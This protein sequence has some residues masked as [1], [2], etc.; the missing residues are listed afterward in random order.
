LQTNK[1]LTKQS[2]GVMRRIENMNKMA[3]VPLVILLLTSCSIIKD[4][5]VRTTDYIEED[6][7]QKIYV[8]EFDDSGNPHI[9]KQ[10]DSLI[11][12]L[13][14][15]NTE[16]N[17][18]F[19]VHG[20]HHN[21]SIDDSNY[22]GFKEFLN[23]LNK[24]DEKY[25]GVYIGWRGDQNDP[26]WIDGTI[27]AIDFLTL[28]ER[29]EVSV[30]IGEKGVGNLLTKIDET[31]NDAYIKNVVVIGHSLGGSAVFHAS[32]ERLIRDDNF[33]YLL[34]NPALTDKE[35]KPIYLQQSKESKSPK[36]VTL[37]SKNDFAVNFIFDL[38]NV[39]EDSAGNS[40]AISHDLDS[41]PYGDKTCV[42]SS[43]VSDCKIVVNKNTWKV[44]ARKD[45][46]RLRETCAETNMLNNWL[47]AVDSYAIDNHN[48]ILEFNQAEAL[49]E[50]LI[51]KNTSKIQGEIITSQSTGTK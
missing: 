47:I 17:I 11:N 39:G 6:N 43:S 31:I 51:K 13:A 28:R 14:K 1:L 46:G 26:L 40:W 29:K 10:I 38:L 36:M 41:C 49:V 25:T 22:V 2:S 18:V 37:Q 42:I 3:I 20:W 21:A 12:D 7:G 33:F 23:H 19:F 45:N 16:Q 30:V 8:I 4:E 35:Y 27:E 5:P 15:N 9:E 34:L 50:F 48:G 24:S 32:K 44:T